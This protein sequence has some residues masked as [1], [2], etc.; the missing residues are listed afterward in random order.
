MTGVK[1]VI[2]QPL[3]KLDCL[4][5]LTNNVYV[6]HSNCS[7]EWKWLIDRARVGSRWT[8]LQAQISEL[9]YKIQQLTD[10]HRQIRA[11]KVLSVF[12]YFFKKNITDLVCPHLS[13]QNNCYRFYK[14]LVKTF[15]ILIAVNWNY[16]YNAFVFMVTILSCLKAILNFVGFQLIENDIHFCKLLFCCHVFYCM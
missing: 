12:F 1:E 5:A 10:I 13:T 11:S 8:W 7:T 16:L 9:E 4:C 3:W 15:D 2:K 6:V 14:N